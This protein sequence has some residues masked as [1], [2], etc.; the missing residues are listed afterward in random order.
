MKRSS[1]IFAA[2][3]AALSLTFSACGNKEQTATQPEVGVQYTCEMHPEVVSDK[4]G[5]CPKCGMT[6]IKK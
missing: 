3:V 4:P 5:E 1:L 2:S 6:L